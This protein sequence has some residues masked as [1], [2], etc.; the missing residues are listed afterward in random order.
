MSR[1][2]S[3]NYSQSTGPEQ[4]EMKGIL[5][6]S[7]NDKPEVRDQAKVEKKLLAIIAPA[8]AYCS[9]C[10][11]ALGRVNGQPGR[12]VHLA[13]PKYGNC[14][15]EGKEFKLPEMQLLEL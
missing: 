2:K 7:Q 14:R 5:R 8:A 11:V 10:G 15:N 6:S 4:S 13:H 12:P 3:K 9:A 1:N